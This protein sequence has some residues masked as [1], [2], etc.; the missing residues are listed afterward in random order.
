MNITIA[1][2]N[3]Y[4]LS[5]TLAMSQQFFIIWPIILISS[6]V[7]I[8]TVIQAVESMMGN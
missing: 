6:F 5:R 3:E 2:I 1:N 4:Y 8:V 7:M